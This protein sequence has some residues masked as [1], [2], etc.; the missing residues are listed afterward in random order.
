MRIAHRS[1]KEGLPVRAGISPDQSGPG[2]G[3]LPLVTCSGYSGFCDYLC[4]EG[5]YS[6][7]KCSQFSSGHACSLMHELKAE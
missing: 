7:Y 4:E 2:S 5:Q 1:L 3:H 6:G